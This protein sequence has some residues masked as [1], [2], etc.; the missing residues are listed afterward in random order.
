MTG[1]RGLGFYEVLL[2]AYPRTFRDDYGPDMVLLFARQLR[3]ESPAR[4]WARG[5][6]DLALT[7]PSLHLEHHMK[8]SLPPIVALSFTALSV[9]G[10]LLAIIGGSSLGMLAVGLS[11]TLAAGVLAFLSWQ[12][13]QPVA[14]ERPVTT[15]WWQLLTLG[16]GVLS[17]VAIVTTITGEVPQGLWWPMMVTILLGLSSLVGG[18]LLGLAHLSRRRRVAG[19]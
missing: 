7:V 15:H 18:L 8:R 4:I 13:A 17:A 5:V 9:A 3:D 12:R 6:V 1:R 2:R 10:A 19:V 16:A 11:V 14:A